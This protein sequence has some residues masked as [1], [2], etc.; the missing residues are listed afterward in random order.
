MAY[1]NQSGGALSV[2]QLLGWLGFKTNVSAQNAQ[3]FGEAQPVSPFMAPS[4]VPS[5]SA[6]VENANPAFG[7]VDSSAAVSTLGVSAPDANANDPLA[8]QNGM[9]PVANPVD[10]DSSNVNTAATTE[11][12]LN[13]DERKEEQASANVEAPPAVAMQFGG[14]VPNVD[15]SNDA[16]WKAQYVAIKQAYLQ[17][18]QQMAQSGGARRK[19]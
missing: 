3:S 13:W 4:I 17:K 15:P 11:A 16:Y 7:L 6:S 12:T 14:G 2:S 10:F 8:A 18:K 9:A 5:G 1:Y 19:Y